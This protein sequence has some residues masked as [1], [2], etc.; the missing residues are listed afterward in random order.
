MLESEEKDKQRKKQEEEDLY[1]KMLADCDRAVEEREKAKQA[2]AQEEKDK[3]KIGPSTQSPSVPFIPGS[4][5]TF[6]LGFDFGSPEVQSKAFQQ[7]HSDD[8]KTKK[9]DEEEKMQKRKTKP[10]IY[11]KSPYNKTKVKVEDNLTDDEKLLANSIF[12]M[13]GEE[14]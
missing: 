7:Q 3:E 12:S 14:A 8:E 13:Q 10:S 2:K 11:L 4:Q 9:K 6:D 5:P 1:A